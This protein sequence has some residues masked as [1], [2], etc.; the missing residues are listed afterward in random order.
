MRVLHGTR[1][2]S[3][4]PLPIFQMR[5]TFLASLFGT[6]LCLVLLPA[7]AQA[8]SYLDFEPAIPYFEKA[9]TAPRTQSD[10]RAL[11]GAARVD[12]TTIPL[13]TTERKERTSQTVTRTRTSITVD[14]IPLSPVETVGTFITR[15]QFV[16]LAMLDLAPNGIPADC[17][18]RLSPSHYWLLF[19]DVPTDALYA[20]A[21]CTAMLRGMVRG[22]P[23]GSFRPDM[24]VNFA[25]ASKILAKGFALAGDSA[26]SSA[27]W[28]VPSVNALLSLR[29]F[30]E[31]TPLDSSVTVDMAHFMLGRIESAQR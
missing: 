1:E 26:D 23:D 5:S 16:A 28:Y 12:V 2:N 8:Y 15:S 20:P 25:E 13:S 29:S 9:K 18:P 4:P 11:R 30:P 3:P 19:R 17:Y 10:T 21:L 22:Y 24:T 6:A 7:S 27:P 14:R 31:T